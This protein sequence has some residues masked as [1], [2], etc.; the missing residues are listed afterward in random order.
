MHVVAIAAGCTGGRHVSAVPAVHKCALYWTLGT[1]ISFIHTKL[2]ACNI[3][4]KVITL[5]SLLAVIGYHQLPVPVSACHQRYV[6]S[7]F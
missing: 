7:P 4:R 1:G 3:V 2:D 6:L 5:T